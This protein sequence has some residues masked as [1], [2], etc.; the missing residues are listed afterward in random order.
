MKTMKPKPMKEYS[1][2]NADFK[3]I[4]FPQIRALVNT[5]AQSGVRD[6]GY[7]KE[8]YLK[9]AAYFDET[10]QFLL[11]LGVVNSALNQI[12]L[13]APIASDT[14]SYVL[15]WMFKRA[16]KI[17]ALDTY[18]RNFTLRQKGVYAFQPSEQTN[19]QTSGIRNLLMELGMLAYDTKTRTY[20]IS[21]AGLPYL[22]SFLRHTSA[23]TLAKILGQRDKIGLMAELAVLAHEKRN[24]KGFSELQKG[25][26]HISRF[27]VGDGYDIQSFTLK[28]NGKYE[29]KYIEVKAV[30]AKSFEFFWSINEIEVAKA[31]GHQYCLYLV[32][33]SKKDTPDIKNSR[34]ISD[35]HKNVFEDTNAREMKPMLYHVS[36][37]DFGIK[38]R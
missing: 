10:F 8:K 4:S 7:I 28:P 36:L 27:D 14:K 19:L 16:Y 20:F 9:S 6:A 30:S 12:Y 15:D 17:P 11:K 21:D 13:S 32:P 3:R 18:F 24:L 33:I 38:N 37:S 1:L 31:L 35:P 2:E 34:I 29:P 23:T 26:L 25:V 5:L 22:G